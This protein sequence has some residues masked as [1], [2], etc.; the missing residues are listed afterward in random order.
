MPSDVVDDENGGG[1]LNWDENLLLRSNQDQGSW[2]TTTSA[3]TSAPAPAAHSDQNFS[4]NSNFQSQS[5]FHDTSGGDL[6]T[7]VA[8]THPSDNVFFNSSH[9][10]FELDTYEGQHWSDLPSQD[11]ENPPT[12][13]VSI[14]GA[15]EKTTQVGLVESP[16]DSFGPVG[17][18]L[19]QSSVGKA[20]K[21]DFA[22]SHALLSPS[23]SMGLSK[24]QREN[25]QAR[26]GLPPNHKSNKPSMSAASSY[27]SPNSGQGH[28]DRRKAPNPYTRPKSSSLNRMFSRTAVEAQD[29]EDSRRNQLDLHNRG[30]SVVSSAS[31]HSRSDNTF[32]KSDTLDDEFNSNTSRRSE[33]RG[34]GKTPGVLRTHQGDDLQNGQHTLPRAKGF[35]IQIGSEVFK[36]SGASIMSDGQHNP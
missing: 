5:L 36:L 23:R 18:V 7:P 27:N 8:N 31:G 32:H 14:S 24:S 15:E 33:N 34:A 2:F 6:S 35:S 17:E 9:Q 22:I 4:Q 19:S 10:L 29:D 20:R 28:V 12:G 16:L 3:S 26:E 13:D 1:F 30:G 25:R 11:N 21:Q